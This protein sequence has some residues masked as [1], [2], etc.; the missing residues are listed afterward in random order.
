MKKLISLVA[1]ILLFVACSKDKL[2]EPKP[3]FNLD[4]L[5]S[6]PYQPPVDLVKNLQT[7]NLKLS[8]QAKVVRPD[9]IE[10]Y[11]GQEGK[12]YLVYQNVGLI[13]AIY[14]AG[15]NKMYLELAQFTEPEYAYGF[16]S[17]LKPM[18]VKLDSIGAE[19]YLIGHTRYAVKDDYVITISY[20]T[21]DQNQQAVKL[22]ERIFAT[23]PTGNAIPQ[24]FIMFPFFG[25]IKSSLQFHPYQFENIPGLDQVYSAN[26]VNQND[27]LLM[28][29]TMDED[30]LKFRYLADY[31]KKQQKFELEERF[32]MSPQDVITFEHPEYGPVAAAY[33][34]HKLV[35]VIGYN[36]P[37]NFRLVNNWLRGLK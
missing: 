29:L 2:P 27:T 4:N 21:D 8:G 16:Y 33:V 23:I 10:S 6:Y 35:G 15:E 5:S 28:F 17:R 31:A 34:R 37:D 3:A 12:E 9:Q 1:V 11:L 30:S 24:R 7:D 19:S 22:C 13:S 32:Q 20:D 25:L 26:V 18:V 14:Q 36:Q